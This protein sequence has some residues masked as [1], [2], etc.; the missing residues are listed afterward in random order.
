MPVTS[1]KPLDESLSASHCAD[2]GY[3]LEGLPR[4]GKCP[5]CGRLYGDHLIVLHGWGKGRRATIEGT[6]IF[7]WQLI[8]YLGAIGLVVAGLAHDFFV[9]RRVSAGFWLIL[10]AV[11]IFLTFARRAQR[12]LST[13]TRV[14]ISQAGVRQLDQGQA[15]SSPVEWGR[16][17]RV[18]V[19]PVEEDRMRLTFMLSDHWWKDRVVVD[20][21]VLCTPA[22]R[23]ALLDRIREFRAANGLA[24]LEVT[25][26]SS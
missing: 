20:A 23:T 10:V 22:G 26:H 21:E 7:S 9:E 18:L 17:A 3:S 8:V 6:R 11:S 4:E 5:E 19:G 2:C 14:E 15:G 25:P 13:L 24:K 16:I 1:P 12:P